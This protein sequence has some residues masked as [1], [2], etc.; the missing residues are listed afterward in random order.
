M[1]VACITTRELRSST[2]AFVVSLAVSDVLVGLVSMPF[3]VSVQTTG[4]PSVQKF[5]QIYTMWLCADIFLGTASIMNLMFVSLDR[6]IAVTRPLQYQSIMSRSRIGV[7]IVFLW[8]YSIVIALIKMLKWPEYPLFVSITAFFGP[9][10]ITVVAYCIIFK[11][12]M[13]QARSIRVQVVRFAFTNRDL[14]GNSK[15][16]MVTTFRQDMKAARTLSII[17]GTFALC[18]CPFFVIL[19]VFGYF[20]PS[21]AVFYPPL[22]SFVK[23]LHYGN[24]AMNPI[25][26]ACLNKRFRSAFK[27]ILLGFYDKFSC[28]I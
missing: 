22:G 18:W 25:L 19:L 12:A 7:A 21:G 2:T 17:V 11:V 16:S 14:Q 3:W 5:P 20:K 23:W 9:L 27:R 10:M 26:Y 1:C 6:L 28:S 24:S 15:K 13:K 4:E 8:L